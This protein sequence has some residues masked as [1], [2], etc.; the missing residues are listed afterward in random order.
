MNRD[1]DRTL[2]LPALTSRRRFVQGLVAGGVLAAAGASPLRRAAAASAEVAVLR[3]TDFDLAVGEAAVNL[4]GRD[5]IG[6][7]VNGSLPAPILRWREGDT[8]TLNVRNDL[9]VDTAIHWHGILLPA[10]MDGVPGLSFD[11]IAPG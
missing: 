1:H 5:G 3:G 11:G 8:V 7:V 9:D 6:T 4:T 10:D 2:P